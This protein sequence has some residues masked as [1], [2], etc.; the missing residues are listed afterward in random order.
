MHFQVL[1]NLQMPVNVNYLIKEDKESQ[2]LDYQYCLL[3]GFSNGNEIPFFLITIIML[4]YNFN[5]CFQ[6][7]QSRNTQWIREWITIW[8]NW[9]ILTWSRFNYTFVDSSDYT[10]E[11][12]NCRRLT[13]FHTS[14]RA[15]TRKSEKVLIVVWLARNSRNPRKQVKP[16]GLL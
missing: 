8:R 10:Q 3:C 1:G 5:Q 9:T 6:V 2:A 7:L 16:Y 13:N 15:M 12:S 4:C 11:S 14:K